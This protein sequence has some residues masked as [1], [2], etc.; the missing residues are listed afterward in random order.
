[1]NFA[2]LAFAAL[3]G[4]LIVGALCGLGW[5]WLLWGAG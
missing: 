3:A 2:A 4:G 5:G 1:M